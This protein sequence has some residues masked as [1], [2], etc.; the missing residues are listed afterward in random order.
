[1]LDWLLAPL[2]LLWPMSVAITYVVAQNIAA[3]P[4]DEALIRHL[5]VL[6]HRLA[7]Y[8]VDIVLNM[9]D[10][11]RATLRAN[12]VESVFW[13]VL[14]AHNQYLGGDRQLPISLSEIKNVP[15]GEI[16]LTDGT[17]GGFAVRLAYKRVDLGLG[18]ARTATVVVADT[19]ELRTSLAN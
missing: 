9:D 11:A 4:Y 5:T 8:D 19:T 7:V 14:G 16:R 6:E 12:E 3:V 13:M 10:R 18:P 15:V 17:L 2:F 1:M